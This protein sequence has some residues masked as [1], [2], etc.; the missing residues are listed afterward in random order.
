MTFAF[1]NKKDK[2]FVSLVTRFKQVNDSTKRQMTNLITSLPGKKKQLLTG[3]GICLGRLV[4]PLMKGIG[5]GLVS[6]SS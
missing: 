5:I 6:S 3:R 1:S 4:V 2:I